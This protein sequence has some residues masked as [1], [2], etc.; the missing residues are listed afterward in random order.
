MLRQKPRAYKYLNCEIFSQSGLTRDDILASEKLAMS[1]V[2]PQMAVDPNQINRYPKIK[3]YKELLKTRRAEDY[4]FLV[5]NITYEVSYENLSTLDKTKVPLLLPIR[6]NIELLEFTLT[7]LF[8]ND[9]QKHANITIIDDRSEEKEAMQELSRRFGVV[10]I[11]VD[12][13][14]PIFNFSMLNNIAAYMYYKFGADDI[15]LWNAD[16]WT[17]NK[18]TLPKLIEEHASL[19]ESG[20][21]LTGTKL[22]YPPKDFCSFIK[23]DVTISELSRDFG[24]SKEIIKETD[25]FEKTQFGGG[26]FITPLSFLTGDS[27]TFQL[28]YHHRRFSLKDSK[29]VN[30]SRDTK[31]ITG[32]FQIIDLET[33]VSIGG[34]SPSLS[35]SF[36]DSDICLKVI[37]EGHRVYYYGRDQF[38][39]HGESVCISEKIDDKKESLKHNK[40]LSKDRFLSDEIIY[41][42]L[43]NAPLLN[44]ELHG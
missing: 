31:F 1:F 16:L 38:L 36:Q 3:E 40:I 27:Y 30:T 7:N 22:L 39:Y 24:V 13:D 20:V 2:Q 23:D 19:K 41:S 10:Y 15:I 12:Y 6:D 33:F 5:E 11:R 34:L 18:D 25:P 43:W 26:A 37:S 44:G 28:P 4:P 21:R 35:C 32:A 9:V 42:L 8:E 29:Q 14:S 17:P